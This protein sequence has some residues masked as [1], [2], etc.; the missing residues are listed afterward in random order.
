[1]LRRLIFA[2]GLFAFILFG[3]KSG[4]LAGREATAALDATVFSMPNAVQTL[5]FRVGES[6]TPKADAINGFLYAK[7]WLECKDTQP[8]LFSRVAVCTL[9]AAGRTFAHENNWTVAHSEGACARCE[10]WT[11]PLARATLRSVTDVSA[12]DKTHAVVTYAYEVVPNAFGGELGDWM[13][14]NPAAWCASDPRAVGVWRHPRSGKADF[15]RS[16]GMWTVTP[17]GGSGD[18]AANFG[19]SSTDRACPA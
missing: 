4:S 18:F 11:V 2:G 14:K 8:G 3:C 13:T 12:S 10:T 1:M 19:A 6:R 7:H 17:G 15:T 9:D 16:G 5:S